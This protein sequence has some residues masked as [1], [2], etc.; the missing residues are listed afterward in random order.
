MGT[1]AALEETEKTFKKGD[2]NTEPRY[3]TA[4]HGETLMK[5]LLSRH[6]AGQ[7]SRKSLA[8]RGSN[9]ESSK[10]VVGKLNLKLHLGLQVCVRVCFL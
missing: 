10:A 2:I 7:Q 9:E 8:Y 6:R 1:R 5:S 3:G 4:Q